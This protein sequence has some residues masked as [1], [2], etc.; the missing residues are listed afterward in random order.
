MKI[1]SLIIVSFIF[2]SNLFSQTPNWIWAKGVGGTGDDA[3]LSTIYDSQ[4][5]IYT[6][7]SFQ[8]TVDF[9][10]GA[11]TSNLIS[12]GGYDIFIS[13][14]DSA[15]NYVWA[16]AIGGTGFDCCHAIVTDASGNIYLT[17]EFTGTVDF[18]PAAGIFNLTGGGHFISKLDSSGNFI[19]A[20]AVTGAGGYSIGLDASAN[21][22]TTGYFSGTTDFNPGAGTFFLSA[23]SID[24][25]ILK[26][27]S[28][29]N[30]AWVKKTG[31]SGNDV[32][33]SITTDNS[34]NG[35]VYTTGIFMDTVDF[36]PGAGVFNLISE[37][38]SSIFILKLT[39]SGDLIWAKAIGGAANDFSGG[40]SITVSS[41]GS[42]NVY[43]TGFFSGANDFDPGP[44]T[45]FL[46]A[47]GSNDIFISKIDS[48]GNFV[49]SKKMGGVN[50]DVGL[51]V[52][53]DASEN[54]YTSGF[55]EGI[56]DFDPGA[57]F[58]N[59][60]SAGNHDI[61]ISKFDS[62]GNFVWAKE[63]GGAFD[64]DGH[65]IAVDAY[66]K[67]LLTGDFNSSLVSFDATIL[68]NAD[69]GT[70]DIFFATLDPEI[71]TV[72]NDSENFGNENLLFP[73]PVTSEVTLKFSKKVHGTLQLCNTTGEIFEQKPIDAYGITLN[74]AGKAK[75][76]YLITVTDATGSRE[77]WKI[78]KM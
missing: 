8:E 49:W 41:S 50:N 18:D 60:T 62:S 55:F 44:A 19:W 36:D 66:G 77:V 67:I 42:G 24:I 54:I 30:F 74:L 7:G 33:W 6:G 78:M 5:N 35:D 3:G 58:F 20:K 2:S 31:S 72:N 21:V 63:M 14:S 73:N 76:I 28:A 56:G 39:S 70:S 64:D 53:I 69:A 46:T 25:F 17:G 71:T 15:G 34:G 29:G 13:K 40:L 10:P 48:A 12:T 57:G 51:T 11:G 32:G 38:T 9:D 65:S 47:L 45:F 27:D 23:G 61:F 37:G 26:L 68:L 59:L 4:R 1:I 52:A 16:K 75:G 22:Y 43:A